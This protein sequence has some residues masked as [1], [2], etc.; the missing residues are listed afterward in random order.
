[1]ENTGLCEKMAELKR[2]EEE[3]LAAAKAAREEL[4][5]KVRGKGEE[6]KLFGVMKFSD[7]ED[8]DWSADR[9]VPMAQARALETALDRPTVAG[10]VSSAAKLLA[11]RRVKIP[12]SWSGYTNLSRR[13]MS[14]L[15]ESDIGRYAASV[16]EQDG[17]DA[18]RAGEEGPEEAV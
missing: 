4:L 16:A 18:V 7:I 8:N 3:T 12:G 1:M 10:M 11:E 13:T 14:I 6:R 17:G 5:E 15:E 2:L 9:Y